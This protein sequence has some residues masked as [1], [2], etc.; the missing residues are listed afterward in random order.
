VNRIETLANRRWRLPNRPALVQ[1]LSNQLP[2]ECLTAVL[3]ALAI[4]KTLST[5]KPVSSS[6]E[7]EVES[8]EVEFASEKDS[9]DSVEHSTELK[10]E[11][12]SEQTVA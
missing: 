3:Q 10:N 7:S 4:Y 2:Y 5:E 6:P 1:T 11:Q 8:H 12:S 9:L